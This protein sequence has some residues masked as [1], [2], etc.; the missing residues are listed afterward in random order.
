MQTTTEYTK[1]KLWPYF[2]RMFSISAE[3]WK[4]LPETDNTGIFLVLPVS[5]RP[6]CLKQLKTEVTKFSSA[7]DVTVM[8]QRYIERMNMQIHNAN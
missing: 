6:P 3:F 8:S 7:T 4:C 2:G 1:D 5:N